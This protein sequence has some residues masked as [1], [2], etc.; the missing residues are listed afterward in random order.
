LKELTEH[1]GAEETAKFYQELL[2]SSEEA[3]SDSLR[4]FVDDLV[5]GKSPTGEGGVLP[6][7]D[8]RRVATRDRD[9]ADI[10]Y[11]TTEQLGPKRERTPEGFLICY[12]V[13]VARTGEM[14]YGPDET[15]IKVGR[16]GRV[17]IYRN[18]AEVFSP[19]SMASLNG[20]P[21]TD[22]HPPVDVDPK[23]WRYYTRG[24]VVNPRRG[25]GEHKDFLVA[26][27]IIFDDETIGD[28]EG[29]K[30]EVSCGYNPDYLEIL[31]DAGDAIPG[32]G[33]QANILYNHLALVERGRCGPRCSIG[34]RRT[35]DTTMGKEKRPM[36]IK[37]VMREMRKAFR[38]KDESAFD[39]AMEELEEKVKEPEHDEEPDTIEV[40]NH[41]PQGDE[42]HG[43]MPPKN[44]PE[45][46]TSDDETPPWLE[47]FQKDCDSKFK[48][49]HDDISALKKWAA[50]EGD[51]P[52]HQDDVEDPNL[53]MDRRQ[54]DRRGH[55]NKDKRD[56]A[57]KSI[58]GELEFEAPPGTGDKA[59]RAKD[60]MYLEDSFQDCV[61][62]AEVLAPGIRVP[63]FDKAS[64]PAKTF[65]AISG[66][67]RTALDLAY[68]KPETRGMID[69]AVGGRTFD[70]KTL[71]D[72]QARV[73]FNVVAAQAAAA[74][75]SR[76]TDRSVSTVNSGGVTQAKGRVNTIADLN[77][78]NKERYGRKS[79]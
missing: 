33:E 42:E 67:R 35:V 63:T 41:I 9:T 51:E 39:D 47:K 57:N 72:G 58:L 43:V 6:V 21:V 37:S 8:H 73:L 45:N 34:D 79:A 32:E 77:A 40:H 68:S 49:I 74:N 18:E 20:K 15:P 28:V 46:P 17:K 22:D 44:P 76:A 30:R 13:P 25:D 56:E 70:A 27:L 75:N 71:S 54:D 5:G 61:S 62:K 65:K 52:E 60:S 66:L 31:N 48:A 23:N 55:D 29:D 12:D 19:K 38:A 26:D 53:E 78:R 50:E 24:V 36:S 2:D 1:P 11:Y 14:I 10:E 4:A 16:D 64:A 69:I 59:K 7:K 3:D